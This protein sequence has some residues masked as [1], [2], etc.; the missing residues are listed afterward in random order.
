MVGQRHRDWHVDAD[1]ADVD[2]VGE[3]A[4]GVAVTCVD[5][6]AV[7]VFVGHGETERLFV[8]ACADS[9]QDWAEDLFFVDVHVWCDVV[10]E[11]WADKEAVFIALQREVTAID[12]EGCALLDAGFDE[13]EDVCFG[14]R[15][16]NGPVIDVIA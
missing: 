13:F 10:K 14:S 8:G 1:H 12:D 7:A 16:H 9:G 15:S 2:A 6:G 11:V 4:G 5:R 3:I